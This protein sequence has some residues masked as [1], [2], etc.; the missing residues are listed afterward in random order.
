MPLSRL[1]TFL[2]KLEHRDRLSP[3][4]AEMLVAAAGDEAT[5]EID[6]DLVREGDHPTNSSLLISG[7][8]T[9]YRLLSN[10]QRQITAI[11]VPGDFV[12]LHSFLLKEMDHSVGALTRCKVVLY[13]HERLKRITEQAP[14]LTRLLWL[15]T[16][17]DSSIQREWIVAMGRRSAGQQMAHLL[18]ELYVRL[19]VAG[20]VEGLS[21]NF[22]ITQMQLADALGMSAVHV[23]RVLQELRSENLFTWQGQ[24]IR[25]LDWQGLQQRAAFDPRYLHLNI[26]SR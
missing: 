16:L 20:L 4:E 11:H 1:D 22:P 23:N 18:C 2:R 7:L 14:H 24:V 9:R 5:F 6:S 17:I 10:G 25:I 19:G 8:A 26:E 3:A 21:F 12:D 15:S 13:P